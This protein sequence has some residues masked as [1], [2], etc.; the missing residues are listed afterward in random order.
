MSITPTFHVHFLGS[1][2]ID[3][4]GSA[5]DPVRITVCDG[6]IMVSGAAGERVDV[7]DVMGRRVG[8]QALQSG[9]YIVR[10]G[11]RSARKV[12]VTR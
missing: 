7:Y 4:P 10:V 5:D 1:T 11:T 12:V 2:G 3:E 6:N 9:V 8:S